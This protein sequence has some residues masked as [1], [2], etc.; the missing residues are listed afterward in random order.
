MNLSKQLAILVALCAAGL[1]LLSVQSLNIIKTNL[2]EARKHEIESILTLVKVQVSSYVEQEQQ[3]KISRQQAEQKVIELLTQV[4]SG[5][6]YIWA[7]GQDAISKVHPNPD[8]LGAFQPSYQAALQAVKRAEFVFSEGDYPKAGAQGLFHKINGMTMIPQWQWVFGYGIYLDDL[9]EDFYNTAVDFSIAFFIILGFIIVAT[10]LLAR[11]ILRNI[12]NNIG[13]EPRYVTS[14][15]NNI[16]NGDLNEIIE[17]KFSQESLLGSVSRMQQ[18]LRAMVDN[19]HK[20]AQQLTHASQELTAQMANISTASQ[21]SSQSSLSTT[22]AIQALSSSIEEIANNVS[23]TEKNSEAAYQ[24]SSHAEQS[25][26]DSAQSINEISTEIT[27]S[28]QEIANLQKRSL[29]IGNI[30]NVIREIAEQTNLLAL[31]AAIEAARAGESGRGFAVVADEVRTLA[32]RTANATAEI[33]QT[34]KLTQSDTEKVMST[35]QAVLPKVE[36]SVLS[37]STVTDMLSDIRSTSDETLAKIREVSRSS[38]EQSETTQSL[39]VNA[40]QISTT[41]QATAEA[42]ATSKQSTDKL[43]QLAMALN[44]SVRYFKL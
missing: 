11:I 3:G 37:A 18:S 27:S 30:V 9:D 29:E 17:G 2:T 44:E 24:L 16:A 28:S 26:Q 33:T 43:N 32:S 7:N 14:V 15:T 4:R 25:V 41:I 20:S 13:G 23:Q 36:V 40:Q 31:N 35:M 38:E 22:Q 42:I 6:S 34:I 1:I 5:D 8:Q 21:Q 10:Y 12:L 39:A 19:I